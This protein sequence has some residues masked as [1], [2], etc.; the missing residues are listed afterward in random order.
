MRRPAASYLA[1]LD[2]RSTGLGD[3]QGVPILEHG[4]VAPHYGPAFGTQG[5]VSPASTLPAPEVL[6]EAIDRIAGVVDATG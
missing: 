1:W 6:A 2:F 5:T 4:R 3:N